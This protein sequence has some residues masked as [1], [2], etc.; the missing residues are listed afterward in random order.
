[1]QAHFEPE[2]AFSISMPQPVFEISIAYIKKTCMLEKYEFLK[3]FLSC[4]T[5]IS[6][7]THHVYSTLKRRG[8][9]RFNVVSTWNA[10]G[11]FVGTVLSKWT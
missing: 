7:Q 10:R 1:M 8:N 11:V 6:L 2:Q 9:D 5:W 3:G 4:Q